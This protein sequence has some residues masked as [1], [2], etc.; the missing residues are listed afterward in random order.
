MRFVKTLIPL[1]LCL[2]AIGVLSLWLSNREHKLHGFSSSPLLL[3]SVLNTIVIAILV[4]SYGP[5]S[6]EVNRNW[7]ILPPPYEGDAKWPILPLP[8]E[9]DAKL[10]ILPLPY[11]GDAKLPIL[12]LPYEGDAKLPI[13]PTLYERDGKGDTGDYIEDEEEYNG[14]DGYEEDNVDDDDHSSDDDSSDD[15][16]YENLEMRIESFIAK[17]YEQRKKESLLESRGTQL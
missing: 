12:P 2:A 9:G 6:E 8:Y 17:V 15:E 16:E 4:L 11:E 1:V 5:Y 10:P 13:L 7:P 3:F 14:S